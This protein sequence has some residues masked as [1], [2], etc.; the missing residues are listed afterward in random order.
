MKHLI[1][2]F[3]SLIIA[4]CSSMNIPPKLN[5]PSFDKKGQMEVELGTSTNS[6]YQ[7]MGYSIT[8]NLSIISSG[9]ISYDFL[10]K[11]E[12]AEYRWSGEYFE[13]LPSPYKNKY[14]DLAVGMYKSKNETLKSIYIGTGL[15]NSNYRYKYSSDGSQKYVRNNSYNIFFAQLNYGKMK[16]NLDYGLTSRI[17]YS[18]YP[19]KSEILNSNSLNEDI[20]SNVE[21]HI[22][23][24]QPCVYLNITKNRFV[25]TFN[26]GTYLTNYN[27]YSDWFVR[28]YPQNTLI[29]LSI[30]LKY[31]LGKE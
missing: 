12:Y 11:N 7:N 23:G 17:S 30:G 25:Y 26:A 2:V 21:Y 20:K 5:T 14:I 4:G 6:L 3:T 15:G 24:I 8:D 31:K 18:F 22:F 1:V 16:D 19:F 27:K 10:D 29:H 9:F 13:Y 28:D